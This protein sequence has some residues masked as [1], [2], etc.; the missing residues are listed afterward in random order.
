MRVR[1]DTG[2]GIA[3][4]ATLLLAF[5]F[6]ADVQHGDTKRPAPS[7]PGPSAT[8]VGESKC[9][10]CHDK[11]AGEWKLSR[12]AAHLGKVVKK[13]EGAC[14]HC[15]GPASE[16]VAAGDGSRILGFPSRSAAAAKRTSELCAGCHPTVM[17]KPHWDS[18]SHRLANVSCADCHEFHSD[19]PYLLR[20]PTG[21]F[22]T[23][24]GIR[25]DAAH[26]TTRQTVVRLCLGCHAPVA[27][28]LRQRS[29]HPLL[30][31]RMSCTDCHDVHQ[32]DEPGLI[33]G[34]KEL[35][36]LCVG[37]HTDKRGPFVFEHEPVRASGIG[38]G[39]TTC[40][41]PHGSPNPKLAKVFGRSLCTQCHT[42][43]NADPTH[44]SRPGNCWR[45]GCHARIHGSN[46]SDVFLDQ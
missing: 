22:V 31:D 39:C 30:E 45:A 2:H 21:P 40:H 13:S 41:R 24:G 19:R 26:P 36:D 23:N 27:A 20:K 12:H 7:A 15:H 1:T 5:A 17:D 33:R 46:K 10:A 9:A 35:A 43:I 25:Y 3:I 8:F 4:A 42:D 11:L 38:E 28:Q 18:N 16:H 6:A 44:Q 29:H 14:E 37:C 32:S 34:D